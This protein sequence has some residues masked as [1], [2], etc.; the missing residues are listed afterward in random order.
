MMC[1]ETGTVCPYWAL[2]RLGQSAC[3]V[4]VAPKRGCVE[5]L[6]LT[7]VQLSVE[8]TRHRGDKFLCDTIVLAS[9]EGWLTNS[10]LQR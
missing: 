2:S 5:P 8:F 1:V 4:C 10:H 7:S 6:G 9:L 3:E